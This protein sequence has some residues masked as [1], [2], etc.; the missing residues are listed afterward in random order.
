MATTSIPDVRVILAFAPIAT[1][2]IDQL[3]DQPLFDFQKYPPDLGAGLDLPDRAFPVYDTPREHPD[4]ILGSRFDPPLEQV[5]ALFRSEG[6][7]AEDVS[8]ILRLEI[9]KR[10][11]LA[12]RAN[13]DGEVE[14]IRRDVH[15][16]RCR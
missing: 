2:E 16:D 15:R 4:L 9:S 3:L 1:H 6:V 13:R 10:D 8:V 12:V 11:I 7:E 14:L 5:S